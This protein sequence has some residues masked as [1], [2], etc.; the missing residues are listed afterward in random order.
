MPLIV[1]ADDDEL[2]DVLQA[3][4]ASPAMGRPASAAIVTMVCLIVSPRLVLALSPGGG[5]PDH[6]LGVNAGRAD[7]VQEQTKKRDWVLLCWVGSNGQARRSPRPGK[8]W[9]CARETSSR[10][11]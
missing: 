9:W 2:P 5:R 11:E 6:P 1:V 8:Q 3:A 7:L 10:S 4:T